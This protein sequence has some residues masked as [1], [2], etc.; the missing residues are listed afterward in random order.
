MSTTLTVVAV[1]HRSPEVNRLGFDLTA[2]YVERCWTASLGCTAVALL[3]RL[4]AEF[5]D[6]EVVEVHLPDLAA[7]LG[8]RAWVADLWERNQEDD[9][10]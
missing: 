5:A 8:L 4:A 9:R 1:P 10:G 2:E 3:R 7:A 6:A